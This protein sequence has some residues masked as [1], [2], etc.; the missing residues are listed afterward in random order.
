MDLSWEKVCRPKIWTSLTDDE[1]EDVILH[2]KKTSYTIEEVKILLEEQR[3]YIAS[4]FE[5]P[6]TLI[7]NHVCV[8]KV[9]C[10]HE[11]ELNLRLSAR[12]RENAEKL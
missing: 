3:K 2:M 1:R 5:G 7:S 10:S 11:Y 12:V 6:T 4:R 8:T 9:L